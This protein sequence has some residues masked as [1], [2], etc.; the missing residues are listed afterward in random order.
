MALPSECAR[1]LPPY[2]PRIRN[3]IPGSG[4]FAHAALRVSGIR[5]PLR[6]GRYLCGLQPS[7]IRLNT[8]SEDA[9]V[10]FRS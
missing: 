9:S 8:N 10:A 2:L 5:S 6:N 3:G 1:L 4:H 7:T